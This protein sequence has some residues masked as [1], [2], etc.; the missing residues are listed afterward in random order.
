MIFKGAFAIVCNLKKVE[1][2]CKVVF[3]A[4]ENKKKQFFSSSGANEVV[5]FLA[6]LESP[7]LAN[8]WLTNFGRLNSFKNRR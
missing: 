2:F 6:S 5:G 3:G 8:A 1:T 7:K 4:R